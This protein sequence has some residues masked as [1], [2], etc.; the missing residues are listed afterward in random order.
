MEQMTK[1]QNET[2]RSMV[3]ILGVL[4][5]MG[6]LS[7]TA[8][9]GITYAMR[10]QAVV[11]TVDLINKSSAGILTSGFL[12]EDIGNKG[13]PSE[14]LLVSLEPIPL[15]VYTSNVILTS[16]A[17][18]IKYGDETFVGPRASVFSAYPPAFS[19][20]GFILTVNNMQP[21]I[22]E[23]V[24]AYDLEYD[25][26]V[27]VDDKGQ[28]DADGIFVDAIDLDD[29]QKRKTFCQSK[30]DK[31]LNVGFV[32]DK[33]SL[34]EKCSVRTCNACTKSYFGE[35]VQT[36]PGTCSGPNSNRK[37]YD[38]DHCECL[39][40]D[41]DIHNNCECPTGK[42]KWNDVDKKCEACPTSTPVWNG[43]SCA[44]C[45]TGTPKWNGLVC[46][47]CL[48]NTDCT[49]S[50]RPLC[51]AGTCVACPTSMPKWNTV[52]KKCE[53]CPT[54]TPVWNGTRGQCEVCSSGIMCA[55]KCC[56][57][58]YSCKNNGC[59]PI[60]NDQC[61]T[62]KDCNNGSEEGDYF[63]DYT[64]AT[65]ARYIVCSKN[66]NGYGRCQ[67]V[68]AEREGY[69][70]RYISKKEMDYHSA[71]NFC[72]ALGRPLNSNMC[73][74]DNQMSGTC[75][76]NSSCGNN[77]PDKYVWAGACIQIGTSMGHSYYYN[78]VYNEAQ[79][80]YIGYPDVDNGD[81]W[82]GFGALAYAYCFK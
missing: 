28:P 9:A 50:S 78:Y 35:C 55:G 72:K 68:E 43:S 51:D 18:K 5:I 39:C 29:A 76:G 32:F 24:L 66:Y 10:R 61:E 81:S 73:Y 56:A 13:N 57:E 63:C 64:S 65:S 71:K 60:L 34:N 67:K 58:G 53:A 54:N 69:S 25:A 82:G 59:A 49:D 48:T 37:Y 77:C 36:T 70:M 40:H 80:K 79:R 20:C 45:P 4:A 23:D 74:P 14:D 47:E 22:C 75:S 33:N 7:L 62:N 3:E 8:V 38:L 46:V 11:D 26:V 15:N 44:A 41:G 21:A 6:V 12:K 30:G 42:P 16:A 2:G 17:E 52:T 1:K 19:G 27:W 31:T